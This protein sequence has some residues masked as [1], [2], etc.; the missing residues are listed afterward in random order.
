MQ[1]IGLIL[2]ALIKGVAGKML[3][4]WATIAIFDPDISITAAMIVSG[5]AYFYSSITFW[6]LLAAHLFLY[7][8]AIEYSY[9]IRSQEIK[10]TRFPL[11]EILKVTQTI[12]YSVFKGAILALLT[13]TC[14]KL[15]GT[16]LATDAPNIVSWLLD[17][18]MMAFGLNDDQVGWITLGPLQN[19]TTLILVL[20]TCLVFFTSM[21]FVD[22][23]TVLLIRHRQAHAQLSECLPRGTGIPRIRMTIVILLLASNVLLVGQFTGFSILVFVALVVSGYCLSINPHPFPTTKKKVSP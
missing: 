6:F 4:D 22:R 18:A 1:W 15:N 9:V 16:Y 23:P 13:S 5:F 17:D 3:V 10:E 19:F 7:V 21:L 12:I 14:I 20:L 8:V 11:S 2:P